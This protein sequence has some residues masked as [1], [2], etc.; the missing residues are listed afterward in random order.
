MMTEKPFFSGRSRNGNGFTIIE[1]MLA[2]TIFMLVILSIY[3]SWT[4]IIRGTRAGLNA[5]AEVQRARVAMRTVEEALLASQMFEANMKYYYFIADTSDENFAALSFVARL[6]ES[7][8]GSGMFGDQTLRRVTF[9]AVPDENGQRTL[10]MSQIPPLTLTNN[11]IQP[12]AIPLAKDIT[13][14]NLRFWDNNSSDW[15]DELTSTNRLPT[16]VEITLGFGKLNPYSRDP[17]EVYQRVVALPSTLITR[18]VQ[19]PT[20]GGGLRAPQFS[21]VARTMPDGTKIL[22][23]GTHILPDGTRVMP[24]GTRILP[25]GTRITKEGVR[26]APR[27]TGPVAPP[28]PTVPPIRRSPL[29]GRRQ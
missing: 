24:D 18:D 28:T 26:T 3:S 10:T 21:P 15:L 4:A 29:G 12:Y 20:P 22:Q 2:I 9:M 19:N 23:D 7:F 11:E 27:P 17:A 14:F 16:M 5:A 25:D 6:P 13:M 8:P 1:I